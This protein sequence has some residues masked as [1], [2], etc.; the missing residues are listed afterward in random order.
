[1]ALYSYPSPNHNNLAVTLWEHEHLTSVAAPDGVFGTAND[2]SVIYGDG[3][4]GLTVWVRANIRGRIRGSVWGVSDDPYGVPLSPN[5]TS[6]PRVD[7]VVAR[8]NR[9]NDYTVE[10]TAIQGTPASNPTPPSPVRQITDIGVYD[11][12]LGMVRVDPGATAI[13]ADKVTQAHWWV[14]PTGVIHSK[15]S[16][17]RPPHEEGL[18]IWESGRLM[19][20]SGGTWR[21]LWED[22]GWVSGTFGAGWGS[23]QS[24]VIHARR[25]NGHVYCRI[26]LP[27]TGGDLSPATD[28]TL[29]RLPSG[30]FAPDRIHWIVGFSD[31][32]QIARVRVETDGRLILVNHGG[33]R[34]N[35]VL[36]V[37]LTSWPVE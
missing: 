17:T 4:G 13:T 29:G 2:P 14:T 32:Q 35:E 1:M 18:L 9:S 10:L 12:P 25:K 11:L 36:S 7:L 6:N 15:S 22:T 28:S 24:G 20:S 26:Y 37:T 8:L 3:T 30:G 34:K 21:Q 19:L 33:I 23:P 27:R 16:T 5:N 31:R